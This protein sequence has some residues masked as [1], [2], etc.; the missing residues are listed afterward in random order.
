MISPSREMPSPNRMSNSAVLNG[1][2][3]LVLHH[4]D[5]G[6]VA[7]GLVALLDG[8]GAAD[9]Q[10]HRGVELERVAARR[11]LGAAEHDA[12]LHADL[13]DEDDHAVGLLDGGGEL[14]QRLAHQPR[15]QA[16]QGVAH[17][18]FDFG[19]GHQG[20]DRVHHDQIHGARAHQAVH[21]LQ[22]L[23]AGVGLADQDVVQV[24]AQLLRVLVSSACSAS[25]KA[26]VPPS[27]CIS[28]ITCSVSVVLPE[29]SGP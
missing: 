7:D 21:D 2:R 3:D 19:L 29:D 6:F 22:R 26:Q 11:G 23:L 12:D 9:V 4:L 20:G 8:A 1:G 13:V 15:L 5:L 10:A 16:G 27:F 17:L 14:A 24:H 25:M 18:A 28:A